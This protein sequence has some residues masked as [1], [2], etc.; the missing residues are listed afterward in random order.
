MKGGSGCIPS[1]YSVFSHLVD[2]HLFISPERPSLPDRHVRS[3]SSNRKGNGR[4]PRSNSASPPKSPTASPSISSPKH[5]SSS[6][7]TYGAPS[8]ETLED[9]IARVMSGNYSGAN[10]TMG[11]M[12][13]AASKFETNGRAIESRRERD[14]RTES[15]SHSSK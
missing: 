2:Q 13:D 8:E 11:S 12:H 4:N 9:K 10:L 1:D 3:S 7:T 6:P 15:V 14:N 5:F